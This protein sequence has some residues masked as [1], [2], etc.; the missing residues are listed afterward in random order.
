MSATAVPHPGEAGQLQHPTHRDLL[1]RSPVVTRSADVDAV[2]VPAIRAAAQLRPATRLAAELD[3]PLLVLCSYRANA[4]EVAAETRNAGAVVRPVDF[5]ATSP[6]PSLRTT[7]LLEHGPF[8]RDTDT[9]GK[10]NFGLALARLTGWERI[11]FLDDDIVTVTADDVKQAAGLL[12]RYEVVGLDNTG[13]ADNSVVCHANRDTGGQ[14]GTFIG[15]GAMVFHGNR[16]T[17]F[18][19][20]I[21]NEDWFFLLD[22][23]HITKC[24]VHGIFQQAKFDPYLIKDRAKTQ[25]LGDCLAEGLFAL[26]D[27]GKTLAAANRPFWRD[28]LASR[29]RFIGAILLRLKETPGMSVL[30]RAQIAEALWAARGSLRQITPALCGDYLAAWRRDRETWRRWIET[31]PQGLSIEKAL[32]HLG[33]D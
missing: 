14:Q 25:E 5:P 27:D 11:L 26:L 16:A 28:F 21:Y 15:S 1:D 17:S 24:A 13:F 22:G 29:D 30:R 18:F 7:A 10:R 9:P 32:T 4:A 23:H 12:G 20:H 19:P 33:V 2:I 3:C 8:R 6:L 31:L